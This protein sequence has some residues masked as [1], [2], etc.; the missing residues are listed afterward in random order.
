MK[1]PF[2]VLFFFLLCNVNFA[3]SE[4]IVNQSRFYQ[5]ENPSAFGLNFTNKTGVLYSTST[6]S[7][8][9]KVENKYFFGALSFQDQHF[10]LGIDV[11]STDVQN[12]DLTTTLARLNFIYA[13]QI[14]TSIYF[15][16]SISLGYTN[17]STSLPSFIFEDQINQITG[18]ISPETIDP[19]AQ[20]I[21]VKNYLD[22]GASFLL[23]SDTFFAGFSF[24]HLN[25]PNKSFIGEG[26]EKLPLELSIQGGVELNLNP[27]KNGLLP[28]SSYLFLYNSGRY[29]KNN[30]FI[31]MTQEVLLSSLSLSLNQRFSFANTFNFNSLGFGIGIAVENFDFGVQFNAPVRK[32]NRVYSS[33]VFELYFSFDFSPFRRNNRGVFKRLQIDNY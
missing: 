5:V 32:I 20:Q 17:T 25:Q 6:I 16:P 8:D 29:S 1:P 11:N 28:D 23:H 15:L 7:Q 3:Q 22:L 14:N 18:F 2:T 13:V 19:L 27:Y 24:F 26:E 31:H 21:G 12:V 9:S 4:F 30:T 10:S 33:N